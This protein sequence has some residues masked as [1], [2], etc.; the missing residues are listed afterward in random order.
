VAK[1]TKGE[2]SVLL[3]RTVKFEI[4]PTEAEV[5]VLT[6]VS[7]VLRKLYNW[8]LAQ[9][10]AHFA[11]HIAP[12][13]EKKR[14][15]KQF[16][17]TS[18]V[19]LEEAEAG[20]KGAYKEHPMPTLF[21]QINSLKAMRANAKLFRENPVTFTGELL[22]PSFDL[23]TRNWQEE[24]LD[25]LNGGY[26][27]F[28]ALRQ[29]GDPDARPPKERPEGFFQKI[30]GRFGF[31]LS[32]DFSTITLSCG[33]GRKMSFPIASYQKEMLI[34]G[35]KSDKFELKKFE[36]YRDRN[37]RFWISLAYKLGSPEVTEATPDSIVYLG[38]GTTSIGVVSS[39][40]E[41]IIY[42]WRSDRHWKPKI[43]AVEARMKKLTRGS[44]QWKKLN[45]SRRRMWELFSRQNKQWI[46]EVVAKLLEKDK[47]GKPVY[48]VHFVVPV[49]VV[50][51]KDGKLAD[52]EKPERGGSLG[53]NWQ[54]QSTG[55]MSELVLWLMEKVKERGGSVTRQ[56]FQDYNPEDP[57][58]DKLAIALELKK[59]FENRNQ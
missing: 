10:Q 53:P 6:S 7:E 14:M 1:R 58:T 41:E 5:A 46:R 26:T 18:P 30:P 37:G 9:R 33:S 36:L 35:A 34:E 16:L 28:A 29:K 8:A 12:W 44:R 52:A 40:G 17:L 42:P 57:A 56:K 22:D 3:Y 50:R 32:E 13:Y 31:K 39:S 23:I 38:L 48:G 20:I 15:A 43:E 59:S 21:D 27:S 25:S 2:K 19:T 24:T 11:E 4:R 51:S 45:V 54:V 47:D 55:T 49:L